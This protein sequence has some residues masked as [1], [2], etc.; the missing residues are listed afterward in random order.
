MSL[1]DDFRKKIGKEEEDK[2][3][4]PYLKEPEQKI[5]SRNPKPTNLFDTYRSLADDLARAEESERNYL[6]NMPQSDQSA[7]KRAKESNWVYSSPYLKK[8]REGKS[9]LEYN[10]TPWNSLSKEEKEWW[11]DQV[12]AQPDAD[13]TSKNTP[14]QARYAYDILNASQ[15]SH[16]VTNRLGS[17]I[18]EKEPMFDLQA[19]QRWMWNSLPAEVRNGI[20]S[21]DKKAL[22]YLNQNYSPDEVSMFKKYAEFAADLE[23]V[24]ALKETQEEMMAEHPLYAII[25]AP[26]QQM[27]ADIGASVISAPRTLYNAATNRGNYDV[28]NPYDSFM[29]KAA[30]AGRGV[31]Q[32]ILEGLEEQKFWQNYYQNSVSAAESAMRLALARGVASVPGKAAQRLGTT[33]TKVPFD[34]LAS[35]TMNGMMFSSVA[36]NSLVQQIQKGVPAEQALSKAI[37]EGAFECIFETVSFDKLGFFQETPIVGSP[38]QFAANL[39][40]SGFVEGSE[41]VATDIANELYDYYMMYDFSDFKAFKDKLEAER[42]T[43]LTD[44]EAWAEYRSE[45]ADKLLQSFKGGA[46]SGIAMGGA[47]NK[48]G[49]ENYQKYESMG[50]NVSDA[51]AARMSPIVT[52]MWDNPNIFAMYESSN[53]DETVWRGMMQEIYDDLSESY[54]KQIESAT[55]KNLPTIMQNINTALNGA[56]NEKLINKY[57]AKMVEFGQEDGQ[58]DYAKFK[59]NVEK[60]NITTFDDLAYGTG[61]SKTLQNYEAAYGKFRDAATNPELGDKYRYENMINASDAMEKSA[62]TARKIVENAALRGESLDSPAIRKY[63]NILG[64]EDSARAYSTAKAVQESKALKT[65]NGVVTK[66]EA[67]EANEIFGDNSKYIIPA[68]QKEI[69]NV[70]E[71]QSAYRLGQVIAKMTGA[72]VKLYKSMRVGVQNGAFSRERNTIYI[73]VAAGESGQTGAI[74]E[75]FSHELTHWMRANNEAGYQNLLAFV[76][77]NENFDKLVEDRINQSKKMAEKNRGRVLSEDEAQ[78][79]IVAQACQRMLS[80]SET[81]LKYAAADAKGARTFVE[82]FKD[83]IKRLRDAFKGSLNN[84]ATRI[85]GKMEGLAEEWEKALNNAIGENEPAAVKEAMEGKE[86]IAEVERNKDGDMTIAKMADRIMYSETTYRNGGRLAIVEALREKGYSAEDI[87]KVTNRIDRELDYIKNIGDIYA[88]QSFDKLAKNLQ[89]DVKYSLA[90]EKAMLDRIEASGVLSQEAINNLRAEYQQTVY[91]YVPNG[92]YPLNIDLQL[93]CKK[94]IAYENIINMMLDAGLLNDVRMNGELIGEINTILAAHEFETQCLGC[95]V[96]SR[97]LQMQ[98]WAETIAAEWNQQVARITGKALADAEKYR[99][100]PKNAKTNRDAS[101]RA[102]QILEEAIKSGEKKRSDSSGGIVLQSSSVYAKMGELIEFDPKTYGKFLVADDVLTAEGIENIRRF[103]DGNLFSIVKS[104]YGTA[105]PKIVQAFNPYNSEVL[106]LT[107]DSI[108]QTTG[109]AVPGASS[110]IADAQKNITQADKDKINE[111]IDKNYDGKNLSKTDRDALF[112]EMLSNKV[113]QDAIRQY[114]LDVGGNRIQS[115]SD[116]MIENVFDML[117]IFHDFAIRDFSVHGYTKE[118]I[119]LRLFGMTGAKWNGSWIAHNEKSMG[120]ELSGLMPYTAENAKHGI[121]V[122]VDGE[123]YVIQ[124]DDYERHTRE[125]SFI[126]SI[127]FKDAIAIML[128]PR[129]ADNVGTITIGFSDKHIR[130]MLNSPYF[131]MVIPYHSSGMIPGFAELVGASTYNDYTDYQNTTPSVVNVYEDG[132]KVA[133]YKFGDK[134]QKTGFFKEKNKY[135]VL[136]KGVKTLV[137]FDMDFAFN[138]S[139]QRLGD[140]R[141]AATEYVNWCR[142]EHDAEAGDMTVKVEYAPKFSNSKY[143]YDFTQERNYYKLLEDF[144]VYNSREE[145]INGVSINSRQHGVEMLY[146]GDENGTLSA[147]QLEQYRKDLEQTGLFSAKEIDKYVKKAQMT[148]D[149]LVKGEVEGR[150]AYYESVYGKDNAN[151]KAAFKE[152]SDLA[153]NKYKRAEE[154]A[155]NVEDYQKSQKK[156]A[157]NNRTDQLKK[158]PV[159]TY[160]GSDR[161]NALNDE[162]MKAVEAGDMEA[163]QKYVDQVAYTNNYIAAAYHGT[164]NG[165]FTVFGGKQTRNGAPAAGSIWFAQNEEHAKAYRSYPGGYPHAENPQTYHVYLALGQWAD[166]GNGRVEALDYSRNGSGEAS[167][168]LKRVAKSIAYSTQWMHR[169]ESEV[170]RARRIANA[171]TD[172][173]RDISADFVWQVTETTQFADLCKAEGLDSVVAWEEHHDGNGKSHMEKTYGVFDAS[174]VKSADP[175]TYDDNGNV[176]PLTERFNQES[177]DIRYSVRELDDGTQ[178]VKLDG[179]IFL[180][181]DGTEMTP[182][183]AYNSLVGKTITFQDGDTA[184]FV[185]RLPHGK[186]MYDEAFKRGS[187]NVRG[188]DI[189]VLNEKINRNYVELLENSNALQKNVED[190]GQRHAIYGID[191]FDDREVLFADDNG[192]YRLILALANLK[193]G[194]RIAYAKKALYANRN[195]LEKIKKAESTGEELKSRFNQPSNDNISQSQSDVN[196]FV[197]SSTGEDVKW[198]IR[199]EEPPKKTLKGYKVFVVK[200]GKLYPPMVANPGGADTPIGVWLNADVGA[201]APDSKTGRKQVKA[202]GKGTQGGSGSLAFRPGWHLG[203]TPLATQ[204]DRLNPETGKK[205]LFPENF[206]WAECDVAADVDYQDEAMSYGYNKNGKFQHSLAGLPKL[207]VNGYYKYRTNPNPE[208]VP[209]LITGAMKVN[210]ILSDAEVN[211]ILRENGLPEKHRQGGDKTLEQLGLGQHAGV[212]YAERDKAYTIKD[213]A[214]V[215]TENRV[216]RLLRQYGAEHTPNYA[217]AYAAYISPDDFLAL[218]TNDLSSIER[219]SR[220]LNEEELRNNPQEIFLKIEEDNGK[221]VVWGHE[222]RHRMVALRNQGITEVAISVINLDN[223]YSKEIEDQMTLSHQNFTEENVAQFEAN[224]EFKAEITDLVPISYENKDILMRRFTG[225]HQV[226]YSYRDLANSESEIIIN[227][228]KNDAAL[229]DQLGAKQSIEAYA[230]EYGRLKELE[231][232]QISLTKQLRKKDTTPS[233]REVILKKMVRLDRAILNKTT[234][235]TEMRNQRVIR[236]LLVNEWEKR[237]EMIAIGRAEERYQTRKVLEEKYGKELAELRAKSKQKQQDIRDRHTINERKAHII[238]K[239]KQLMDMCLHPTEKKKVPTILINPVMEMLDAIDYWTPKEG[240]PVT[241]KSESLRERFLNFKEAINNYQK[242]I[243]EGTAQIEYMFD[244][245]F[246]ETVDDLVESVKGIE[247]V[248]DMSAQAITDLDQTLT[249][250]YHLINRGNKMIT[251]AHYATVNEFVDKTQQAMDKRKTL[252]KK[253][254]AKGTWLQR[255]NAGMSDTYAFGEYAGEGTRDIV[256][257]LSKAFEDKESH[258]KEAIEFT[259]DVLKPYQKDLKKWSNETHDFTLSTE[260]KDGNPN[261]VSL[262]VGNMMELYLLNKR[263]QARGHI[264]GGGIKVEDR[265]GRYTESVRITEQDV[266]DIIRYLESVPG[267]IEVADALQQYGATTVTGWGNQASNLMYG[268]SKFTDENYWQIRSDSSALKDNENTEK[269]LNASMYRLQNL[270][271]TK[272][273]KKGANNAIYIG[274]VFDTWSKTI[275]EMTSYASI[276]PATTDA[277]R[278]WNSRVTEGEDSVRVKKLLES[279]LGTDMTK[280]FT[281]SIKALNGGIMGTDSLESLVKNLTGK[282]KAAAVA[283]NLRVVLQQPTAYTRAAAVIDPKYLLRALTMKPAAKEAQE[284]SAIAWHKAQGFYSNGLAPSLRKLVIGDASF[285]ENLTEKSLW[286]AGKAD[287]ITWGALWNASKLKVEAENKALKKGSDAYWNEVNK[288]FSD[289]INQTQVVDTPLTKSTWMRGNGLGVFFTAF[290]AEPTKTYS[291]VMERMDKV[292]QNPTSKTAWKAFSGVATVFAVNALVNAMAQALADAARDDDKEKDYWEKYIEKYKEDAKDNLNPITYIPVVKDIFSMW[293]GYSNN[294]LAMQAAQNSVYA[295]QEID[296]IRNGKSKKT[297]FG[298][299]ETIAK[300]VSSWTGIPVGNVMRTLNSIGNVAGVD[301]FRRK[302]YTNAELGRNIALATNEGNYEEA[303]EY[304]DELLKNVGGDEKKAN[305]YLIDY[306]AENDNDI[307]AWAQQYIDD[308]TVLDDAIYA[309]SD[310]YPADIVSAAIRKSA[311]DDGADVGSKALANGNTVYTSNDL[312]RMLEKGDISK[313]QEIIDDINAAYSQAGSKTTAKDAVTRYW[314]PKYLAAS[315]AERD[316]ILRMLYSLKNNGKQMYSAKD[317]QKWK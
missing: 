25:G 291:M 120:K 158:A 247:N 294:N 143:G 105:S 260:D 311:K 307:D 46:F 37:A 78:E 274:D 91:A 201:Q 51:M 196:D 71:Y 34:K 11:F 83:F 60:G 114:M 14:W 169:N 177:N 137:K 199:E 254:S 41:E 136:H 103:D 314:K 240:R 15:M 73:D 175:V 268:I 206:V 231:S 306:L 111:T 132:K 113:G 10:F 265:K 217:K 100:F 261:K 303:E 94:R 87:A 301:I 304:M 151:L 145:I 213:G 296:K 82:R 223:K 55:K 204:F 128:D 214:A 198:S 40:K 45:F 74:G 163:A 160:K 289:I 200:D 150:N 115:F 250:M 238:K 122:E 183:E 228:L 31:Q 184:T 241:K 124:F 277:M 96:E 234:E 42:G 3:K 155:N 202:G 146:P 118:Q 236:D 176:I 209:W 191:T 29:Q 54:G 76:R 248:N 182:R 233:E 44:R 192:A 32:S 208:T 225:E 90:D 2:K 123:K 263:E 285:G 22:E 129:Y 218:T 230:R 80:S 130:A 243:D 133:S 7:Y 205:E 63:V 92:D 245:E 33:F 17:K 244:P 305:N 275:D 193:D 221:M 70:P 134:K 102:H 258:V 85:L 187:K 6:S 121:T 259:Q 81:F 215:F 178:Y 167:K 112:S 69:A 309:L 4:S 262:T 315:G 95:F 310:K 62:E 282:A 185:K 222:G 39:L 266:A 86:N 106:N 188:A 273:V 79:E 212:M 30:E 179:N 249:Q 172:I 58:V 61:D 181:E 68:E 156:V 173:A 194:R 312:N 125:K 142:S 288:V 186:D 53:G 300:A 141:A 207:P 159:G 97:R 270:G 235:L 52:S 5:V 219:E 107:F 8:G 119:C 36:Q 84:E 99:M 72:N 280:V 108:K 138:E 278:W 131:R 19:E 147:D 43:T 56:L 211:Q 242:Q 264:Y 295:L 226:M 152:I 293:K 161:L 16:G 66:L 189:R 308:P 251:A 93:S 267:A 127:G 153:L 253:T 48:A 170:A 35:L 139:L 216:N 164:P 149:D 38:K 75:A 116:F 110:Y 1:I 109:S 13:Y 98:K 26:L 317:I 24:N 232:Q 281:D 313:A 237:D 171:L 227:A 302:K 269:A 21:N 140:A 286:L 135:Y 157:K 77:S 257:M 190:V 284:H 297:L 255:L 220:D 276:L 27:G 144:N 126:Q 154:H 20:R 104:R 12:E 224:T 50:L 203:E 23:D 290:M 279:K 229:V 65:R 88:S 165:G 18:Y 57:N 59:Q 180:N 252:S 299:A 283:G 148:F 117:Q 101:F 195:L 246:L 292:L 168:D 166:I 89:A 197:D 28:V 162:Y 316:R 256:D 298:Q 47:A 64:L 271:R 210:R 287:D 272:A 49:I 9:D 239:T 174:Q 67:D